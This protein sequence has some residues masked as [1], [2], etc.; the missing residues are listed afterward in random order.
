MEWVIL[1]DKI[2]VQKALEKILEEDKNIL[3]DS[4][5][6]IE[7]LNKSVSPEYTLELSPFIAAL[8][9][10]NIGAFLMRADASN[11]DTRE[12]AKVEA[13]EK[14]ISTP[15]YLQRELAEEVVQTL[16][17]AMGWNSSGLD[18]DTKIEET[19]NLETALKELLSENKS[20]FNDGKDI[21]P[22]LLTLSAHIP[23]I[24]ANQL[25]SFFIIFKNVH[26][27][28]IVAGRLSKEKREQVKAKA[29]K[30][31]T[32]TPVHMQR[33]LAEE[34]VQTLTEAMGWNSSGF[35]T[36]TKIEETINLETALTELLSENKS[37]FNDGKDINPILLTLSAHIPP[38]DAN[39]LKSFFIIFKNVH[40]S[41]IVAGRLSKEKRE[42]VKAKAVEKLTATP[43][44]LQRELAEEVVQTLMEAM[45]WDSAGTDTDTEI[46]ETINL[47]TALKELL[48]ENKSLFNDGKDINPI[49]LTL[50]AHIPPIDANQ[51][52]SF[53]IIFKNVHESLI[54]ASGLS[55]EKREQ[56][57]VEAVKKLK[58][59]PLSE[60]MATSL[61]KMLTT[62]ID[63]N[64]SS[65][66]KFAWGIALAFWMLFGFLYLY[67]NDL[68][69][70][71]ENSQEELYN[72]KAL[73]EGHEEIKKN[74]GFGSNEYYSDKTFVILRASDSSK[75]FPTSEFFQ[76][77]WAPSKGNGVASL[78]SSDEINAKWISKDF[79]NNHKANV[80]V[81]STE[82][83]GYYNVKFTNNLNK[84]SFDVL[85]IVQ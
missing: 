84:D 46:E 76:V 65:K 82:K 42:Q 77:Y 43:V 78:S 48:S 58:N 30:K 1:N 64:S 39:Q 14:L 15:V 80:E 34:V 33:E 45:G 47:E 60:E 12:Q 40:E 6:I 56:A 20:L 74:L 51:L 2:T 27:S 21:N 41:L 13:V 10:G 19:I 44:Y 26:E 73:Q 71:L 67:L 85:V 70:H 68:S 35:D 52:K 29:V 69:H 50:S 23:P 38:I 7:A 32:S 61:I 49:L 5:K 31:L 59:I 18:T 28:L 55:K 63:R 62:A 17:E 16:T 25:K 66:N 72:V 11:K 8:W 53:F 9:Q 36:D 54:V 24:D 79:D 81:S 22:I 3:N 4:Q 75:D 37:L 57:K 83:K